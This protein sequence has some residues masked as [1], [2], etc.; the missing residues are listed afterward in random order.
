ML[1]WNFQSY[2][3]KYSEQSRDQG[4]SCRALGTEVPHKISVDLND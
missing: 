2:S 4:I 1:V 3:L